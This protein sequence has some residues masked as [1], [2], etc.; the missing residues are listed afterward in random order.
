MNLDRRISRLEQSFFL[1][2]QEELD[3]SEF[4]FMRVPTDYKQDPQFETSQVLAGKLGK[5]LICLDSA[6]SC[7]L[8]LWALLP[9]DRLSDELIDEQIDA[10]SQKLE[11]S[12]SQTGET[13]H[14]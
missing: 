10:L 9:L 6:A 14:G 7:S 1:G 3:E 11:A 13:L 8:R 5:T 12:Q 4:L 2:S